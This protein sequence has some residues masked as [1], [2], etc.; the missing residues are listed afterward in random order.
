MKG[1]C[2]LPWGMGIP[3]GQKKPREEKHS[4]TFSLFQAEGEVQ[5]LG[6]IQKWELGSLPSLVK[7][8][9]LT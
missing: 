4:S 2:C 7:I 9:F 5:G 6:I 8:F 3:K 1:S